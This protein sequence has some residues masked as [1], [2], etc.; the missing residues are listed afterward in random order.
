MI[1]WGRG[2]CQWSFF[3]TENINIQMKKW[4]FL[5]WVG[6]RLE[7]SHRTGKMAKKKFPAKYS[8][9]ITGNFRIPVCQNSGKT[10]EKIF[11]LYRLMHLYHHLSYSWLLNPNN[12]VEIHSV[13]GLRVE[14]CILWLIIISHLVFSFVSMQHC[15][16]CLA[17]G[18]DEVPQF[19]RIGIKKDRENTIEWVPWTPRP[20]LMRGLGKVLSGRPCIPR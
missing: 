9:F 17:I 6:K 4:K 2:Y 11:S 3:Q 18:T 20:H 1:W 10:Q 13:I 16:L 14:F 12:N 15:H 19:K 7:G 5:Q 8:L